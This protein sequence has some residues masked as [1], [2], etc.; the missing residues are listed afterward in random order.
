LPC[1][2]T[3]L[4]VRDDHSD[5]STNIG[6]GVLLV[7]SQGLQRNIALPGPG[8]YEFQL[9]LNGELI[10]TKAIRVSL[11]KAEAEADEVEDIPDD[12]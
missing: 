7:G 6:R 3:V 11:V 8:T 10:A 2:P 4:E 1:L 12:A 5:P 9:L